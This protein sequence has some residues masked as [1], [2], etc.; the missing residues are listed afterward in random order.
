M[1]L[2]MILNS[3]DGVNEAIASEYKERDGKFELDV[4]GVYTETDRNKLHGSLESERTE[5]KATKR[6]VAAFGEHTPETLAKL[7]EEHEQRGLEIETFASK[8]DPEAQEKLLDAKVKAKMG[9]HERELEKARKENLELRDENTGLVSAATSGAIN[10]QVTKAFKAKDLGANI[11]ALEDVELWAE[12]V[13]HKDDDGKIVSKDGVGVT[14]GLSPADVLKDMREAGQRPLWFGE[15]VG[16]GATGG[17]NIKFDGESPFTLHTDG[18][19]KG[20]VTNMTK[21]NKLLDADPVKA[22]RMIVKAKA[23][24]HFPHLFQDQ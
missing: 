7:V 3:L 19:K 23:Q 16:A 18:P 13:F 22:K 9:P 14:P 4:S 21:C 11:L 10:N 17:K 1:A 8:G 5:H 15:T 12:R 2:Q 20:R 6:R 24:K